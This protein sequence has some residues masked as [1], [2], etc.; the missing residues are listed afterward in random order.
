MVTPSPDLSYFSLGTIDQFLYSPKTISKSTAKP[1]DA[2]TYNYM[3]KCT[4]LYCQV[5]VDFN[6]QLLCAHQRIA[7]TYVHQYFRV[8]CNRRVF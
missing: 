6:L 1:V 2:T 7:A 3:C 8:L 5:Q 4:V